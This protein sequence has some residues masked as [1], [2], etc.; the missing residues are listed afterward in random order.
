MFVSEG[1]VPHGIS[2]EVSATWM[3]KD[4]VSSLKAEATVVAEVGWP[5]LSSTYLKPIKGLGSDKRDEVNL[6][7]SGSHQFSGGFFP[8]ASHL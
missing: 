4:A 7:I 1:S 2:R 6:G 5:E 3:L 8:S